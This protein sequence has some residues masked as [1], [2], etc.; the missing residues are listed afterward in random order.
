[1]VCTTFVLFSIDHDKRRG[2]RESYFNG[3]DKLISDSPWR[4]MGKHF[5]CMILRD[6]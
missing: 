5:L 3:S 4:I 2:V 6:S 1:M